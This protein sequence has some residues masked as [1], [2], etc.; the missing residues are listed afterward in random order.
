MVIRFASAIGSFAQGAQEDGTVAGEG[1]SAVE[2]F[3]YFF[4]APTVLFIAI[5]VIVYALTAERKKS[6][7]KSSVITT[8]D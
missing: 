6:E 8:I 3:A 1:L 4:A 5:S 7:N 2:T